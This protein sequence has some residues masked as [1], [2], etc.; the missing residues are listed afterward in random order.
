[1]KKTVAALLAFLALFTA[2]STVHAEETPVVLTHSLNS[3]LDGPTSLVL[4]FNLHL[5]N[6]NA[7]PVTGL[8]LSLVPLPPFFA[9]EVVL[10]VP[11]VAPQQQLDLALVLTTAPQQSA[12]AL[13]QGALYFNGKILDRQGMPYVFPAVSRPELAT[14]P[15]FSAPPS[16][17]DLPDSVQIS[18]TADVPEAPTR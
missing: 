6:P 10:R 5:Q 12:D 17:P 16:I 7:E 9:R 18:P 3:S 15:A 4:F 11:A 2:P 8:E 14:T 1:M 13:A